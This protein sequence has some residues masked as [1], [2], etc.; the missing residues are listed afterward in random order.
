MYKNTI[1]ADLDG[2]MP[3]LYAVSLILYLYVV[4]T[5]HEA[6]HQRAFCFLESKL[7]SESLAVDD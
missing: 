3:L 7:C 5:L 1:P 6:L 2:W 4:L